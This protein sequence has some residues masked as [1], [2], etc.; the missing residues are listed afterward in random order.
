MK[1]VLFIES[2]KFGGGS[3]VSLKKHIQALDLTRITPV[4]IFFN[5]ND[6]ISEFRAKGIKVHLLSD[7]VFT[8][9]GKFLYLFA[10]ALFMKGYVRKN[11][12]KLLEVIHKKTISELM[13]IS[14]KEK[15][16]GI[17]LNTELLV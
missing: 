6:L 14:K 17:H 4:V 5:Q 15:I 10:N 7:P 13:N 8:N 3:F 12:I 11:C 1:R 2:G 16:D 9:N